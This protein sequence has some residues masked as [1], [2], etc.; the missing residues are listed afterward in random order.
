MWHAMSQE[1][2]HAFNKLF[3]LFMCTLLSTVLTVFLNNDVLG[4]Q[5]CSVAAFMVNLAES[6]GAVLIEGWVLSVT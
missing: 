6:A 5:A 4:P 2:T 3:S 1:T